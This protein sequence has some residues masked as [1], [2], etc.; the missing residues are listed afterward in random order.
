LIGNADW[1]GPLYIPKAGATIELNEKNLILYER[2]IGYYEDNT[3]EIKDGKSI[4]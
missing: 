1:F 4:L 2:L 3:L